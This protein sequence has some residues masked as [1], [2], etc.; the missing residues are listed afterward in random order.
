MHMC[1]FVN[2]H[3][4]AC[5][6]ACVLPIWNVPRQ[7]MRRLWICIN[8]FYCI[9]SPH[10]D[11]CQWFRPNKAYDWPWDKL[12]LRSSQITFICRAPHGAAC[13][14][15]KITADTAGDI[16]QNKCVSLLHFR[17]QSRL[18]FCCSTVVLGSSNNISCR[19]HSQSVSYRSPTYTTKHLGSVP[20]SRFNRLCAKPPKL[21]V[22]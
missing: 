20:Q 1:M 21:F 14:T 4:H 3:K 15:K 10:Q 18:E 5:V 13:R 2:K 6:C 17:K 8:T 22:D 7:K 11:L 9:S 16:L 19:A 12:E